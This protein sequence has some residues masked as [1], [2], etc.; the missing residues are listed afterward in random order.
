MNTMPCA[1]SGVRTVIP[2]S[3]PVHTIAAPHRSSRANPARASSAPAW[4][5]QPTAR[6]VAARMR[7]AE[8]GGGELRQD[9]AAEVRRARDGQRAE[10]VD[11]AVGP[12][13]VAIDVAG[14]IIPKASVCT[15][16]PPIW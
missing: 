12:R 9:V 1:A 13:S 2:S 15:R 16:M 6:P 10:A 8:H 7:D 4:I 11:D 14:P 5:P 3:V